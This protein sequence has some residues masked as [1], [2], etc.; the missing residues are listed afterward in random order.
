MK[1]LRLILITAFYSLF[2]LII[3]YICAVSLI[4]GVS[5][6]IYTLPI[7][8][9][10]IAGL[11]F[12]YFLLSKYKE[13]LEKYYKLI[14]FSF[15]AIILSL[16]IV[17]G[18]MLRFT[19]IFDMDAI[20]GG[21]VEWVNTGTFK[22]YY[23]YYYYFPNNLG[24]MSFLFIFF[25]LASFTGITDFFAV[26]MII[27][28]L[29]SICTMLVCSLTAK[30][31]A[32]AHHGI[33]VLSFFMLSLPFY[34]IAPAFYTDSL[35][36]PF[37]V[38]I[39]YLALNLRDS[40]NTRKNIMLSVLIG[41][42]AAIGMLIKFT[43]VITVIAVLICL[44]INKK[45]I[46]AMTCFACAAGIIAAVILSFNSYMASEHL[47]DSTK[48]YHQNTPYTHWIMMGLKGSGGYN[49]DD[50]AFTRSF[51]DPVQR[52]QAINEQIRLRVSELGAEGLL[53]LWASK[54][55]CSMG[56][57]TYALSDFLDDN[58]GNQ[59]FLHT[60]LLYSSEHYAD[61]NGICGGV[62]LGMMF[63]TVLSAIY[64]IISLCRNKTGGPSFF[65]AP[66]IAVIGI[67][68]F[69]LIWEASGRYITNYLPVFFIC[70]SFGPKL[71]NKILL[72]LHYKYKNNII[73]KSINN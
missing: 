13:H 23:D 55:T 2:I 20:Y 52:D 41:I 43:V 46:K 28:S 35:S 34:F 73:K 65:L 5:S 47:T 11:S 12:T 25:K 49:G 44:L 57:G 26:G 42:S 21:A 60:F 10:F 66:H 18:F 33:F 54:G 61:Y 59:T 17:F 53:K 8:I 71:I 62:H 37:P 63:F 72:W 9:L 56:N 32:G 30:K 48:A 31:L 51:S 24:G 14:L 3:G 1:N 29:L 38:L 58:P 16:Q 67:T 45:F 64:A 70:A 39:I 7:F 36:L 69:L 68:I 19:P 27:N 50:Y 40:D 22:G 4:S 15:L 6:S